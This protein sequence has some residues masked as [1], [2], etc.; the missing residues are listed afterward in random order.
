MLEYGY[1]GTI[2]EDED[3]YESDSY[4]FAGSGRTNSEEEEDYNET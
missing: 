4:Y 3:Y 1:F 2:Y